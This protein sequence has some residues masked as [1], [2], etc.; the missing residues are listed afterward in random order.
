MLTENIPNLFTQ[1]GDTRQP[2]KYLDIEMNHEYEAVE[3]LP[4]I[5]F[6]SGRDGFK[7][8][9]HNISVPITC[10]A[11][12]NSSKWSLQPVTHEVS[13]LIVRPIL[14][15]LLPRENSS[16]FTYDDCRELLTSKKY[17]S[18]IDSIRHWLIISIGG[19]K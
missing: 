7:A 6:Y 3:I 8:L 4:N 9:E 19:F 18:W 1:S 14:A 16:N 10:I 2:P 15:L 5:S 13:H 11:G 12:C 17:N